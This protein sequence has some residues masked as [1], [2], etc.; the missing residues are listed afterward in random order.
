MTR[1]DQS[2]T[3]DPPPEPPN[4]STA[5][6]EALSV[7]YSQMSKAELDTKENELHAKLN[8]TIKELK[9]NM[10]D[11]QQQLV[12]RMV[13]AQWLKVNRELSDQQK[14][15]TNINPELRDLIREVNKAVQPERICWN[16]IVRR[17]GSTVAEYHETILSA[18]SASD[19]F[20]N[21]SAGQKKRLAD[22]IAQT[23]EEKWTHTLDAKLELYFTEQEKANRISKEA[24]KTLRAQRS[25]IIQYIKLGVFN[26]DMLLELLS[27]GL[28]RLSSDHLG[29]GTCREPQVSSLA[30]AD[31]WSVLS[32]TACYLV[33]CNRNTRRT[34]VKWR[35]RDK[36]VTH[37]FPVKNLREF[38]FCSKR[39][40]SAG[41]DAPNR[42]LFLKFGENCLYQYFNVGEDLVLGLI[43]APSHGSYASQRIC[44]SF[45]YERVVFLP[46][47]EANKD[48]RGHSAKY[49]EIKR[50]SKEELQQKRRA[51]EEE[52]EQ[53]LGEL[54]ESD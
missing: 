7:A 11:E 22:L 49:S 47:P 30:S 29:N 43:N 1:T 36:E 23:W 8:A 6:N 18:M 53:V 35:Y 15:K 13:E 17:K 51:L 5:E 34:S 41:Y 20:R 25:K 24:A 44:Y 38:F 28:N 14:P 26:K 21:V 48:M 33:P 40:V 50:P 27:D 39:L 45:K 46:S 37:G 42:S 9:S 10:N 32:G 2:K 4:A 3:S 54:N 31:M 12:D 52:L 19:V 16:T